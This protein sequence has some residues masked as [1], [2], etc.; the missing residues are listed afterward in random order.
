MKTIAISNQKGGVGKTASTYFLSHLF[1]KNGYKT[2]IIDMDPQGNLTSC[3]VSEIPE[4][5]NIRMLFQNKNCSP[6][7]VGKKLFLIGA[8][9]T[10]SKYEAELKF[11]NFYRLKNLLD[12]Q[13]FDVVFMDCPPSLGLFTS[14]ALISADYVLAPVDTSRFSLMGL[15]D[16]FETVEKIKTNAKTNLNILGVFICAGQERLNLFKDIK[17][18]LENKYHKYLFK[19]VIPFSIKVGESINKKKP[20][21]DIVPDHKISKAYTSLYKEIKERIKI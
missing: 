14:N 4:E 9:I 20:I 1:A 13:Q 16:F 17:S 18:F 15:R 8:D 12:K 11:E 5:N 6:I 3:F 10:L 2:L 7:E 19:T 21:F